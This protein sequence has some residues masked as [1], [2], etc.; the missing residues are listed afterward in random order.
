M[1]STEYP[2]SSNNFFTFA[3]FLDGIVPF[4]ESRYLFDSFDNPNCCLSSSLI[5]LNKCFLCLILSFISTSFFTLEKS[6]SPLGRNFET[7]SITAELSN[8]LAFSNVL[9]T[10]NIPEKFSFAD[11]TPFC[12]AC[13]I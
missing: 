6:V 1:S 7:S 13:G 9:S 3:V 4:N 11:I 5:M 2:A 8:I 12:M 10:Y